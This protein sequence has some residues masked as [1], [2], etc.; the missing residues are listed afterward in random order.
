MQKASMKK[1]LSL[2]CL[3]ILMISIFSTVFA[4]ENSRSVAEDMINIPYDYPYK[5]G[6][7]EWLALKTIHEKIAAC[8]IPED[9]LHNLSDEALVETIKNYPL[10]VNIYAYD[11]IEIG[12]E[13][14]K[15][16][17]NAIA[18]LE[19]RINSNDSNIQQVL[20]AETDKVASKGNSVE[21][22]DYF[23]DTIR[24]CIYN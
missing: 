9:I 3:L 10:A 14:V 2:L 19:S 5:T 13:K 18:E 4:A 17:F 16:Q 7:K 22:R 11:T 23:I 21:F 8:Q 24:S 20:E 6:T 12:Y 15:S 1:V